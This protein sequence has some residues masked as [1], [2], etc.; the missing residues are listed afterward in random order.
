[1]LAKHHP[2]FDVYHIM[3]FFDEEEHEL[4]LN[5]LEWLCDDDLLFSPQE[6]GGQEYV[7][8]SRGLPIESLIRKEES[9]IIM[10]MNKIETLELP[11]DLSNS[12]CNHLINHYM[13]GQEY[14]YHKD[15][16]DY[17]AIAVF[18]PV[19][20]TFEGGILSFMKDGEELYM[21]TF[22]PRDLIIFPGSL[23]HQVTQVKM[24]KKDPCYMDAR[25]SVS[26]FIKL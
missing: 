17:T 25:I 24:L 10:C 15:R 21:D 7:R 13:G 4:M 11:F 19:P 8:T 26:R 12:K 14:G 9:D 18:Y 16:C 2:F 1:M 22:L 6:A 20:K 5:E 3:N 23:D